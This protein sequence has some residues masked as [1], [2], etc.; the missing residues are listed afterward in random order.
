L[1]LTG[2]YKQAHGTTGGV[3][4]KRLSIDLLLVITGDMMLYLSDACSSHCDDSRTFGSETEIVLYE[5]LKVSF[6]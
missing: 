3:I 4:R 1:Y 6:S 5:D 2:S